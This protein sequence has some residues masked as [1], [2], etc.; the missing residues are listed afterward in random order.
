MSK[1]KTVVL[2][3]MSDGEWHHMAELIE[4]AC[5]QCRTNK[6]N[7]QNVI[8]TLSGGHHIIKEHVDGKHALCRYRL[9]DA[10]AKVG[11]TRHMAEFNQLLKSA[12]CNHENHAIHS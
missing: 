9:P 12:R 1:V 5:K 7:V 11:A 8:G 6:L 10:S 2:N 4:K 3:I